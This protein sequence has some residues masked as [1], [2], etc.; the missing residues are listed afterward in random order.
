MNLASSSD[1]VDD[2][3]FSLRK[4]YLSLRCCLSFGFGTLNS[5]SYGYEV[6]DQL[7]SHRKKTRSPIC[8]IIF[9]IT[10][11]NYYSTFFHN[12]IYYEKMYLIYAKKLYGQYSM[13]TYR[14]QKGT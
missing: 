10:E 2:Q 9:F 4:T 3:L 13:S 11:K 6:D 12:K 8:T 1:K 5:E 7:F 14:K